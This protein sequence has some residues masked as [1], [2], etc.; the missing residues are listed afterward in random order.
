MIKNGTF[1]AGKCVNDAT[2]FLNSVIL[3]RL[4]YLIFISLKII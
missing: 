3:K 2:Y 4:L 1:C